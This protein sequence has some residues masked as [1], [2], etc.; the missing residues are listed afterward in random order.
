[1]TTNAPM[2]GHPRRPMPRAGVAAVGALALMAVA[3]AGASAQQAENGGASVPPA[4]AVTAPTADRSSAELRVRDSA[5]RGEL[6]S[7]RGRLSSEAAGSTAVIEARTADGWTTIARAPTGE[8]G[9]FSVSWRPPEAGSFRLRVRPL[10][11]AQA[12]A[13]GRS[14]NADVQVFRPGLASW[15]GPGFYGR[16][17]ACGQTITGSILGVAHKTLP[18][19]TKVTFRYGGRTVDVRVID[20]GPFVGNREW[21]LTPAV[22]RGLGFGSTG[23]VY[24]TR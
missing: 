3:P 14:A 2:G 24:T 4:S 8:D 1:M 17:T 7:I 19:G 18:C 22:K 6:V 23:T 9:R 13:A 5:L 11:E 21:D 16:R 10:G 15:Y 12:A 20:R